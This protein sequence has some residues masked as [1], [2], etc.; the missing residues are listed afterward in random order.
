[1][2]I[3]ICIVQ[4]MY[5]ND[6]TDKISKR[7]IYKLKNKGINSKHVFVP[8]AFEIPVAISRMMKRYNGF[9]AIGCVI[10]GKTPNFDFISSSITNAIM[11][12]SILHKKPIGNAILT[13]L[14]KSQ[15]EK[16][17]EKGDEA[18]EA[19]LKVLKIN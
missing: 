5:N 12:L 9:I 1:M 2:K 11:N 19:V 4:S 10:K 17:I 14:N 7:A 16:R 8:G 18:V 15:A 13:C 3:K 6:I